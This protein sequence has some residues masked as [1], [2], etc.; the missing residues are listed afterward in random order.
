VSRRLLAVDVGNSHTTLGLF[1][2]SSLV[3][4][5]RIT[6][7]ESRTSDEL[8]IT[9]R[10]FFAGSAQDLTS[11]NAVSISSVVPDLT[12]AYAQMSAGRLNVPALII[13]D[14]TVHSLGIQYD[15]PSSV[16]ADRLCGAVA[17]FTKYGGPLVVVDLGTATVFDVVSADAVYLGGLIAPGLLTALESLHSRA[18]LLPRVDPDFPSAVIGADTVSA[19]QSGIL[20]GTVEMVNGLVARISKELGESVKVVATGGFAPL[21]KPHCNAMQYL[22]PDLVLEG[23]R[24]IT[25]KQ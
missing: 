3:E 17:A 14:K 13:S 20:N 22:E 15:P 5:W 12:L 16:G 24:L 4:R 19:I 23:I 10:Q 8:W 11:V 21:L 6:T 25:D 18:A 7:R 9:L 1:D 2:G